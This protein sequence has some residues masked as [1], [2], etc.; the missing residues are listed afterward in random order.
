VGGEASAERARIVQ[1]D[2]ACQK[3][4]DLSALCVPGWGWWQAIKGVYVPDKYLM[5]TYPALG[6]KRQ[7]LR[8]AENDDKRVTAL[9]ATH[10]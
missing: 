10:S 4:C 7:S 9:L 6:E 8:A 1:S 5:S 3:L 2:L